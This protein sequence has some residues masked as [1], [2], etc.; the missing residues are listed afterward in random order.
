MEFSCLI[1]DHFFST[2]VGYCWLA[3]GGSS[4]MTGISTERSI[5]G[6]MT[7]SVSCRLSGVGCVPDPYSSPVSWQQYIWLP[8]CLFGAISGLCPGSWIVPGQKSAWWFCCEHPQERNLSYVHWPFIFVFWKSNFKMALIWKKKGYFGPTF[9]IFSL[10]GKDT[11]FPS[12]HISLTYI[13]T[14]ILPTYWH[15][16]PYQFCK[17][18]KFIMYG[19]SLVWLLVL[20]LFHAILEQSIN[21]KMV[22]KI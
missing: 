15:F 10:Q 3:F 6:H 7:R 13:H 17:N 16:L 14:H 1:L 20:I 9:H 19:F 12:V 21:N 4:H 18:Y 11:K 8:W 22:S 2:D 5:P